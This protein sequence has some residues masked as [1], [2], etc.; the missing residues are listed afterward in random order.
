MCL[1]GPGNSQVSE[2]H[3]GEAGKMTGAEEGLEEGRGQAEGAIPRGQGDPP[4]TST[5]ALGCRQWT[6]PGNC[7]QGLPTGRDPWPVVVVESPS[8]V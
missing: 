1:L 6:G 4:P 3:G 2:C 5:E 7:K 8:H